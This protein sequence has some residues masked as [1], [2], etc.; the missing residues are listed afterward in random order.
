MPEPVF[1]KSIQHKVFG[2]GHNGFFQ[3]KDG[4][5]NWIIYHANSE[6]EQGCGGA[7]SPRIQKFTWNA[8]GSPD[9]GEPVSTLQKL[10]KPSG[11]Y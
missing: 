8:D 2:P 9:F 6:S 10:R 3:S 7:R 4:K 5:E 11:E 1:S